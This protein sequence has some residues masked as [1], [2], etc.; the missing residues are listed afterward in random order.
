MGYYTRNDLPFFHALAENFTH[1][2]PLLL[3]GDRPDR[4]QPSVLDERDDRSQRDRRAVAED[5][6]HRTPEVSGKF[7]WQTYPEQLQAKG[8]SWKVYSTP[9]GDEG[10]DVLHY[11]KTYEENAAAGSERVHAA[12]SPATSRPTA[13]PG[14]CRRSPGCWLRCTDSEHPPAPV[15]SG[16]AA[17]AEILDALT[18]N[19]A[20]WEKTA[21][22]TTYDENGGFF[23][24]VPPPTP[25]PGTPG[26]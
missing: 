23:D 4:P 12:R 2:R 9:D 15:T 11:F 21:L 18:S 5:A 14:R 6:G 16:E 13:R 8:I 26:E 22:F 17:L 20:V 25:P 3:L 1:L 24:H 10:D 19:S 7:T